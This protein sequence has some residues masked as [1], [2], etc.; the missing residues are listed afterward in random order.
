VLQ[1]SIVVWH[2]SFIAVGQLLVDTLNIRVGS[3]RDTVRRADEICQICLQLDSEKVQPA[4]SCSLN[5]TLNKEKY[6]M[7]RRV[8][9][10]WAWFAVA[11]GA[12]GQEPPATPVAEVGL[13]YSLFRIHSSQDALSVNENG[14]A[15]Y[16]ADKLNRTIG[17]V[18]D[19]GAYNSS[20]LD[21]TTITYL[22]GPRLNLRKSRFTPY[23]QF[24]VG[25]AHAWSNTAQ[26]TTGQ[27]VFAVAFGGGLDIALTHR[28][29][30]KPVQAEYLITELP[31]LTGGANN[32]QNNLRMSAGVVL[33]FGGSR[34]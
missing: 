25:G 31:G 22:F 33:R 34:R 1:A 27:N 17:L 15:G 21:Q 20:A 10:L 16:F 11:A 2:A 28:L 26:V 24:L 32:I 12:Y 29:S 8:L 30:L 23:T 18:G 7:K 19:I 9:I 6:I 4:G 5:I 13:D 14:G 3:H